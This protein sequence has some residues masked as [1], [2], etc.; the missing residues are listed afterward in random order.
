[1]KK[2]LF[3]VILLSLLC[4]FGHI[5]SAAL[6]VITSASSITPTCAGSFASL[7]YAATNAPTTYSI[8]WAGSPTGL[9]NVPAGSTLPLTAIPIV[10]NSSCAAGT[11]TGSFVVTNT[12]GSSAPVTIT[13]QVNG[14][15]AVY[16]VTGGGG[17]CAG[18]TGYHVNLSNSEGGVQY[19]LKRGGSP[20]GTPALGLGVPIDF[21]VFT[22]PGFYSVTASNIVTGCSR[23]MSG[24]AN[25]TV[26]PTPVP[27]TVTGGGGYCMGGA[28][29]S[30]GLTASVFGVNYQLMRGG[31]PVGAPLPGAGT[32]IDFGPQ[33]IAGIYSVVATD[34][35]SPFCPVNMIGSP[36]VVVYPNPPIYNVTG[37]GA[38]CIGGYG[39]H[40]GL[41]N[42]NV[43]VRYKLYEGSTFVT[44][45]IGTGLP[46]D[47]G[48]QTHDGIYTATASSAVYGCT[49][50]MLD[51]AVIS[52]IPIV[53]PSVS[54]RANAGIV[55][56][57]GNSI[58]FGTTDMFTLHTAFPGSAPTYSWY[59][60]GAFA[61]YGDTL[62]YVP[63]DR[64]NVR[65]TM[66]SNATC[67]IPSVVT[68]DMNIYVD[69]NI[70]P[71]ASV[72]SSVGTTIV[73][74]TSAT[75]S[76]IFVNGGIAPTY[77]W[78]INGVIIAGATDRTFTSSLFKN[79][80]SVTF[81]VKGCA[82]SMGAASLVMH[83]MPRAGVKEISATGKSIRIAPNPNK[84]I[85]TVTSD[86]GAG[87][88]EHV[89]LR[90]TDV[91]GKVIYTTDVKAVNGKVN[92]RV[93]LPAAA[94]PGIYMLNL[95]SQTENIV[96]EI[97]I[98]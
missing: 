10:I 52:Y 8:T 60:N 87:I 47:F 96:S 41:T 51:S 91:V 93:Q 3:G 94:G 14:L 65:V 69:P 57:I 37:G 13:L 70:I 58:C 56:S 49:T 38:Y 78:Y 7:S 45:V 32:S 67:G 23:N 92:E 77:Q 80:D 79:N 61:G 31:S 1:M 2:T 85:F 98:E 44:S 46:L 9:P 11:Y 18:G 88:D 40:V 50:T 86:L 89:S 39:V 27:V 33:M 54:I 5:A 29:I 17:L 64:D 84:G 4:G 43:S 90:V 83:V 16:T 75:I 74:G 26:Y 19:Q 25:I 97:V 81:R 68:D 21:G 6:P 62:T 42:S 72:I 66:N 95:L 82:D 53:R 35:L 12:T 73:E 71:T 30:I 63:A 28:G 76:G 34:T 55:T 36:V 15:P 48:L 22:V 24:G 20:V 59:V